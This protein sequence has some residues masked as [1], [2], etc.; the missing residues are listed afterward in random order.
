MATTTVQN[1]PVGTLIVDIYDSGTKHLV[2]RGIAHDTLSDRPEKNT[3]KLKKAV[4]KMLDKFP[5]KSS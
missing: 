2:W 4:D 5:P 1:V 3:E